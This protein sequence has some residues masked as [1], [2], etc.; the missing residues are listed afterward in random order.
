MRN[1][2][3]YS[4]KIKFRGILLVGLSLWQFQNSAR[5]AQ[6]A[7]PAMSNNPT[8]VE[9]SLA[10]NQTPEQNSAPEHN[11][12]PE[13]NSVRHPLDPLSEA[14]LA[15]SVKVLK[16]GGKLGKNVSLVY[17]GLKEPDKQTVAN[18]KPGDS[19]RR[20]AF[21]V[22]YEID[23]NKTYEAVVDLQTNTIA[24]WKLCAGVQPMQLEEDT[25]LGTELLNADPQWRRGLERRGIKDPDQVHIEMFVVGNPIAI[26]NPG[27]ERLIRA[28]P[29]RRIKGGNSFAEPIEG[30]SALINLTTRKVVVR[31][32]KI[33][34]P[35]AGV[36][37]NYFDDN[38][39]GPLRKSSHPLITTQPQGPS[40]I[41]RGHEVIWQNWR[42][43][44]AMDPREGLVLYT[45]GYE[46]AA[47]LRSILHR[48]SVAEV[49][50]PYGAPG[51]DW[52]WRSP[53]DEGEYGLGRLATS[54]RPGHEVPEQATLLDVPYV[55]SLG[56]VK[57]KQAGLAI[58]EQDGGVLWAHHDDDADRTI[59]RR[60]RQLVVAQM[61]TLGNYDYLTEWI[62]NQDASID[63]K[64]ILNGDVLARG[65]ESKTCLVCDQKPDAEGKIIPSGDE[66]YGTLLAPHIIGINHQH[67]FC[68]RLDFDIDGLNNSLYE[69]NVRPSS[70]GRS[71]REQNT[72]TVERSLLQREENARRDLNPE[73]NRCWKVVNQNGPRYLGHLSGYVLEPGASTIPYCHPESYNRLRT[74][75]M[76]HALW[77]TCYSQSEM[78]PA[79]E[80]PAS[81]AGGLGLPTWSGDSSIENEDLVLW[82][83]VGLTHI[84]RV[85]DW[86]IMPSAQ[87]GFRL[88]PDAFFKRNPA[89]D[90]PGA[91]E[92][93]N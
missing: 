13:Q 51:E 18:F 82:Y 79:G 36:E 87:M 44:F 28:N 88:S 38:G 76:N 49:S 20:Q 14:E 3:A 75:F 24:S 60:S 65:V 90:V 9:L 39:I 37:G 30:L 17:L 31:D 42:F 40:F 21:A 66:R 62:F 48:A 27:G 92:K 10:Q 19:I 35:L 91:P 47:K 58:W 4:M 70:E 29:Y 54:L 32:S 71:L 72:F 43:R 55:D 84:P 57:E 80:Y 61:F 77:A 41:I 74:A 73:T 93:K 2:H 25:P 23:S 67:F 7:P 16:E 12:A 86:P 6:Q 50:V 1:C 89:L 52:M 26:N 68:F 59:T 56:T 34:I 15:A 22:V 69:M 5:A 53:I 63:V 45:I 85:E 8:A 64:V 11:S 81:S 33:L 83:T 78:H 46:D